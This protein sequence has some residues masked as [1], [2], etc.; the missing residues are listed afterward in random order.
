[1]VVVSEATAPSLPTTPPHT[2]LLE[3]ELSRLKA[4]GYMER[5]FDSLNGQILK[6][7]LRPRSGERDRCSRAHRSPAPHHAFRRHSLSGGFGIGSK[8]GGG[9]PDAGRFLDRFKGHI[10]RRSLSPRGREGHRFT[11]ACPSPA[12]HHAP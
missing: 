1:M 10:L 2:I 4:R 8:Q 7:S 11:L 6:I 5:F 9:R 3:E 12:D